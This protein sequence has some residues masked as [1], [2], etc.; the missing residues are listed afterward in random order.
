MPATA[1]ILK[2]TK[3]GV[4]HKISVTGPRNRSLLFIITAPSILILKKNRDWRA[5]G[6]TVKNSAFEYGEI[7][8]FSRCCSFL[9]TAFSSFHV[10]QKIFYRQ[11][12]SCGTSVN[13]NTN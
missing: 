12:Q 2:T 13:N 9:Q 1:V 7:I 3:F 11:R 6:Y 5:S 8:F 4:S 10:F